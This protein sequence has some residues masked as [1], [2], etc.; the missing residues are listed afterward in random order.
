[1]KKITVLSL[2][3]A[4]LSF[5]FSS[6]K[7]RE[8]ADVTITY[9]VLLSNPARTASITYVNSTGGTDIQGITTSSF[10]K[11]YTVKSSS[12]K[13]NYG[14]SLNCYS[15]Y[16]TGSVTTYQPQDVTINIKED[17]KVIKTLTRSGSASIYI[18][19]GD[20]SASL[21]SATKYK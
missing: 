14:I 13:V 8:I 15:K 11:S 1:M 16:V 12:E 10:T 5:T 4:L 21:P 3:F 20:I 18:Y 9:E 6:C 17:D 19:S 2:A 7:K